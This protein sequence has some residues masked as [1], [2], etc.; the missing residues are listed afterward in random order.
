MAKT[1][2]KATKTAK[3]AKA[4]KT[5]ARSSRASKK[6]RV[7]KTTAALARSS[8]PEAGSAT[9]NVDEAAALDLLQRT[10]AKGQMVIGDK[11]APL[12]NWLVQQGYATTQ[13]QGA[14]SRLYPTTAGR[15]RIRNI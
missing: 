4:T 14:T 13:R 7:A 5:R 10:V 9:S 1:A 6:P 12:A 2:K 3:K 15:Q 8:R 11:E